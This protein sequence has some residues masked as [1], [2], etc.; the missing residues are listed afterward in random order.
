M[1]VGPAL[2][3]MLDRRLGMMGRTT[4]LRLMLLVRCRLMHDRL[5]RLMMRGLMHGR[6]R[7]VMRRLMVRRSLGMMF[8]LRMMDDRFRMRLVGLVIDRRLGRGRGAQVRRLVM[9]RRSRFIVRPV[10][11]RR[12]RRSVMVARMAVVNDN[13][14]IRRND[15]TDQRHGHH[16]GDKG[17]QETHE[18]SFRC[19]QG[20]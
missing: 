20:K 5:V 8:R 3:S 17:G 14:V 7:L 9:V 11:R 15:A 12:G 4:H 2:R 18:A 13:D 16:T 10:M 19:L 1:I 6:R